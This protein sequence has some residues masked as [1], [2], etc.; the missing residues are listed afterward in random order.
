MDVPQEN[1]S[2]VIADDE[3]IKKQ[4]KEIDLKISEIEQS[5]S[6]MLDEESKLL[7]LRSRRHSGGIKEIIDQS[8]EDQRRLQELRNSIEIENAPLPELRARR[9]EYLK[10]FNQLRRHKVKEKLRTISKRIEETQ[11][12]LLSLR[13]A[14]EEVEDM[15][16]DRD[17]SERY[18]LPGIP[19]DPLKTF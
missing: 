19:S 3:Y 5:V 10:Q 15:V 16:E 8:R 13:S 4:L 11:G 2:N 18:D 9:N 1:Q 6:R 14:I 17:L 7:S 12:T